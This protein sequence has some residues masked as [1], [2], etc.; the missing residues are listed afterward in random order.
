MWT[1]P[2]RPAPC[3]CKLVHLP[4]PPTP[5]PPLLSARGPLQKTPIAFEIS[6]TEAGQISPGRQSIR[7]ILP[8]KARFVFYLL[9][10]SLFLFLFPAFAS[11]SFVSFGFIFFFLLFHTLIFA[12]FF[13][14]FFLNYF[15]F[16]FIFL[17]ILLLATPFTHAISCGLCPVGFGLIKTQCLITGCQQAVLRLGML[18]YF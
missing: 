9:F 3:G 16:P 1:A 10:C 15:P 12:S 8:A 11:F 6:P 5:H 17:G 2:R 14:G 7:Y 4:I 18:P 13:I